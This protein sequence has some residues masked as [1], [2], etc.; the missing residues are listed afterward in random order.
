MLI[1]FSTRAITMTHATLLP[2]YYYFLKTYCNFDYAENT[3]PQKLFLFETF[4]IYMT[5]SLASKS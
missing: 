5:F 4:F 1:F 3:L 2:W